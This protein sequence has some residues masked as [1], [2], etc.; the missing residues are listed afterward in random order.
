MIDEKLRETI[1][2]TCPSGHR[3]RGDAS[4]I[5]KKVSCPSC[6]QKFA[7]AEPKPAVTD[8]SVSAHPG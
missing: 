8:S 6:Q 1:T 3:L 4:L 2:V 7:I 5:G